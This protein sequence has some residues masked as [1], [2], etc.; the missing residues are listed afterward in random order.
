ME[1]T[2]TKNITYIIF[3]ILLFPFSA[4]S[5]G[6]TTASMN[7]TVKDTEGTVLVGASIKV[8]HNPSGSVVGARSN[9]SG[10][11]NAVGL[12]VGGPFSIET[13]MVGYEKT[14]INDINLGVGQNMSIDI[15]LSQ[16]SIRTENIEVFAD[17]G[18]I[19]SSEKIGA[20]QTIGEEEIDNLPTISRSIHDYS[21]LSPHVISSTSEGSTTGKQKL[22]ISID[23]LNLMN[24]FDPSW[25]YQYF[26]TNSS[27][28]ML[29]FE[30]YV[31]QA[32]IN[33]GLFGQEDLNKI[34]ADFV[35]D[36][37]GNTKDA[38][39]SISDLTSRWQMQLGIR[40]FF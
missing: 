33:A 17:K 40:Y 14:V 11:F 29:R 22:Q 4:F 7:G 28:S 9:K 26:I 1:L 16:K 20:S 8:V 12:R 35:P 2:I 36:F 30:G 21:R 23:I 27:Y 10:R 19:I 3:L 13:S 39:F 32:E 37:R 38:I 31:S 15:V 18:D 6:M 25:G 34:K 5:Q 24:M